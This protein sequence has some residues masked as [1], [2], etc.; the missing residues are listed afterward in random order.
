MKVWE[1]AGS[2][3]KEHAKGTL[4][5]VSIWSMWVLSQSV[6]ESL[7]TSDSF[8]EGDDDSEKPQ[9][10]KYV[11]SEGNGKSSAKPCS[12]SSPEEYDEGFFFPLPPSPCPPPPTCFCREHLQSRVYALSS[13][14]IHIERNL[15]A[16]REGDFSVSLSYCLSRLF[17][18]LLVLILTTLMES[19]RLF[20]NLFL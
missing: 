12:L 16:Q 5:P 6:L 13:S 20:M 18:E 11:E 4:L 8:D 15:P 19:T 9:S 7:Q 2:Q 3:V 14:F 10:P 1:K 17:M